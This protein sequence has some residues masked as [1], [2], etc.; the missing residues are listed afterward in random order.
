[1][2]YVFIL[3]VCVCVCLPQFSWTRDIMGSEFAKQ[4]MQS[5]YPSS[6]LAIEVLFKQLKRN[7]FAQQNVCTCWMRDLATMDEQKRNCNGGNRPPYRPLHLSL[8]LSF[9][10]NLINNSTNNTIHKQKQFIMNASSIEYKDITY[11]PLGTHMNVQ[12]VSLLQRKCQVHVS[13]AY[14]WLEMHI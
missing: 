5:A 4:N 12:Q 8:P 9:A 3:Y 6:C 14:I 2:P 1:M 13:T 10:Y 11:T 7:L